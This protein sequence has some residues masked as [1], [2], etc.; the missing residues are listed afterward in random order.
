[1]IK[2][3]EEF[4]ELD[5][6]GEEDWNDVN[7]YFKKNDRLLAKKSKF[8]KKGIERITQGDKYWIHGE[9]LKGSN[10]LFYYKIV[11]NGKLT[12]LAIMKADEMDDYFEKLPRI[13][14]F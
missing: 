3:F 4:N 6:F 8:N 13:F 2:L 5:P 7:Y 9:P 1:M 10:G 11:G 12:P 14:N